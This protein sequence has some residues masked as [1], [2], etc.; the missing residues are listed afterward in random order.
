VETDAIAQLALDAGCHVG[1]GW[2]YGR[3][4]PADVFQSELEE[5]AAVDADPVT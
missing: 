3:A 4:V 2:L 1:Q 5:I